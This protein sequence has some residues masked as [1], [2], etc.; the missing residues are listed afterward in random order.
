MRS[1]ATK[2]LVVTCLTPMLIENDAFTSMILIQ[3]N[4]NNDISLISQ[5]QEYK[6]IV[7]PGTQILV[8]PLPLCYTDTQLKMASSLRLEVKL[9]CLLLVPLLLPQPDIDGM[10]QIPDYPTLGHL[11]SMHCSSRSPV[12]RLKFYKMRVKSQLLEQPLDQLYHTKI[13]LSYPKYYLGPNWLEVFFLY[14]IGFF[15]NL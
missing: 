7:L 3:I 8:F 2:G 11:L 5:Q 1:R 4:I 14:E 6:Y 12:K 10:V 15:W 9:G 13:L